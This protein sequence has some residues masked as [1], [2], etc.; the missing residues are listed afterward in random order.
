MRLDEDKLETLRRWGH[1]LREA[2]TEEQAAAGRAILMQFPQTRHLE[3][4]AT[5]L[6]TSPAA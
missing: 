6:R 1:G 2:D 4:V 3:A 5:L